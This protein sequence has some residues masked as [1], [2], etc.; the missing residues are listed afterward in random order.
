M[1]KAVFVSGESRALNKNSYFYRVASILSQHLN[2][3]LIIAPC[4]NKRGFI[5]VKK[6]LWYY[7]LP[8]LFHMMF[9]SLARP[10]LKTKLVVA[11]DPFWYGVMAKLL[12]PTDSKLIVELH[13]QFFYNPRWFNQRFRNKIYHWVGRKNLQ[14]ADYIRTVYKDNYLAHKHGKKVLYIPSNY[15]DTSIFKN[16]NRP[17]TIDVLFVGRLHP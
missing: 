12:K 3:M 13:S 16:T 14:K 17:R 1:F 7:C 15:T 5:K 4:K 6:N 10:S 8:S 11:Q 9:F 2:P